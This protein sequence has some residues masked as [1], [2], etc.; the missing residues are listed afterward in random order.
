MYGSIPANSRPPCLVLPT[1][2]EVDD[3]DFIIVRNENV[4]TSNVTVHKA[5]IMNE[6][7]GRL[8]PFLVFL[9][10]FVIFALKHRPTR[11]ELHHHH[12]PPT[13][14]AFHGIQLRRKSL[15]S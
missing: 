11:Q 10:V 6:V 8:K 13:Y 5:A 14:Q 12:L 4:G 3:F 15:T 9:S 7:N 1:V 2:I